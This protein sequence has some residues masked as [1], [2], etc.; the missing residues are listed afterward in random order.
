M[1]ILRHFFGRSR[2]PDTIA[3]IDPAEF[4]EVMREVAAP[5]AIIAAGQ[6]GHRNGLT[7]TAVCSVSD[8]PPTV[9]VCVRR[10]A[11][12]H[13]DIVASGCFSI[14]FLTAE[15]EDVAVQFSGARSVYGEDRF[16]AGDWTTGLSGA[17]ILRESLCTLECQLAGTQLVATHSIIF[18]E[19]VDTR[20]CES[21]A[22]LLYRRGRYQAL[23][24]LSTARRLQEAAVGGAGGRLAVSLD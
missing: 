3:R 22:A 11:R 4:R 5:V 23:P 24:Q 16:A 8:T 2:S 7:A 6:P 10:N 1:K 19:L 18:G 15:Q 13:D 21:I 17:P 12:A 20:K 14:N 9:L